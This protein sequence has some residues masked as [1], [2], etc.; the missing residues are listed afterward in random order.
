MTF[1]VSQR[2]QIRQDILELVA[3]IATD[4]PN[5]AAALYDAY[6]RITRQHAR[7]DAGHWLALRL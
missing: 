5:A 1:R 4:N 2:A 3:Y 7:H 6:E